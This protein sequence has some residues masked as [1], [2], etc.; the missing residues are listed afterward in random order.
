[1]IS[2]IN[3]ITIIYADESEERLSLQGRGETLLELL[4]N[5]GIY[6]SAP[7][8]GKGTCR[9]CKVK[10]NGISQFACRTVAK[11]DMKVEL[12]KTGSEKVLADHLNIP[13]GGEGLGLSADI[14]TTTVAV[15]LYDLSSGKCLGKTGAMNDQRSFGADVISRIQY[16]GTPEG[17]E[18]LSLAIRGQICSMAEE[19]C[20]DLSRITYISIA[21]NTVMEHLFAGLDPTG[22]GVAP[23]T[24]V[25][26]FGEEHYASD[27]LEGFLS[28][29]RIYLCPAVAGYVGG[30]ITAGIMSSEAWQSAGTVLFID[31]GTN[32]EMAM[33]NKDGFTCCATAAGP[34]FEGA[35]I[36]CG[37]VAQD[38]AINTV[39]QDLDFTVLGNT[40]P[41]SICG[42]GLIDAVAA[43]LK[44]GIIDETGLLED[45]RYKFSEKVYISR[46]DI[47]NLQLAKAAIRAGIE[48][49]LK[50]SGN[51]FDDIDEVLIAG[52]FGSYLDVTSA[53]IIGMLPPAL[54]K[55]ARYV[56]NCA[57][58]G[59]SLA[60]T[61]EGRRNLKKI[62][63]LC[64]YEELSASHLFNNEYID[65]MMFDEWEEAEND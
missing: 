22:I 5:N 33:G 6:V 17:L 63:E 49:L 41:L 55:K 57:G 65:A 23:F 31:V 11:A 46:K 18:N 1:M 36:E 10:V 53:C 47:R 51:S 40:E 8:G 14:G 45:E 39:S 64:Q 37:S 38:G 50:K 3:E 62:A 27:Y 20:P 34:A 15:Y 19:L 28:E 32:G 24:P 2:M 58:K 29:C 9:Q 16:A 43:L 48:T 4:R 52:G 13:P 56:G 35:G 21:G 42:S 44:N 61:Y 26:L 25:S 60:L 30:D 12:P 7:C 54:V 59:A